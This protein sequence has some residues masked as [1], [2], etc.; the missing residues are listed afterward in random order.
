MALPKVMVVEPF[1][2]SS[3]PVEPALMTSLILIILMTSLLY[4]VNR[5]L[6]PTFW[7]LNLPWRHY[8][9][10]TLHWWH[11]STYSSWW[12]HSSTTLVDGSHPHSGG[13]TSLNHIKCTSTALLTSGPEK[14]GTLGR[15]SFHVPCGWAWH[16]EGRPLIQPQLW[17]H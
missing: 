1:L 5:W 9:Q 16:S 6:S 17:D 11:H 14:A 3:R 2:E 4:Y 13:G 15:R 12:R 8:I 10:W 7:W